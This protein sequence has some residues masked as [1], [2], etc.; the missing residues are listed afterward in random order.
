MPPRTPN[1]PNTLG[2]PRSA[3]IYMALRSNRRPFGEIKEMIKASEGFMNKSES[4]P[5]HLT[6]TKSG[7]AGQGRVFE[8]MLKVYA[9][10]AEACV[11]RSDDKQEGSVT[12]MRHETQYRQV[13]SYEALRT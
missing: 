11:C 10:A 3:Q 7:W 6:F 2:L 5:R 12:D 9:W 13:W 1:V 8:S 4:V